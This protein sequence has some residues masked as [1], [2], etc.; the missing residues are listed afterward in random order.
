M[1]LLTCLVAVT[2]LRDKLSAESSN[3][4]VYTDI[5][6]QTQDSLSC[7]VYLGIVSNYFFFSK[8]WREVRISTKK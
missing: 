2:K 1:S 3:R 7:E 6:A 5:A 4:N 8:T